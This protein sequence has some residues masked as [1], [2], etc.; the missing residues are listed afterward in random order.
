MPS[1]AIWLDEQLVGRV[2]LAEFNPLAYLS[3]GNKALI[4][5]LRFRDFKLHSVVIA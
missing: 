1:D 4:E 5:S 3:T 2:D